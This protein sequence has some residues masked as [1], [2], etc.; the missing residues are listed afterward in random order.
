MTYQPSLKKYYQIDY[1]ENKGVHA[2]SKGINP[3]VN[4]TTWLGFE[5]AYYDV[6]VRHDNHYA[7]RTLPGTA[8]MP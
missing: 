2:L 8:Q 4:V 7:T 1:C 5:L 6:A 3:K